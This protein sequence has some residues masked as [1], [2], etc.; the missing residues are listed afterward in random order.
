MQHFLGRK[1]GWNSRPWPAKRKEAVEAE[2]RGAYKRLQGVG[3]FEGVEID[4]LPIKSNATMILRLLEKGPKGNPDIIEM[5]KAYKRVMNALPP[6][7]KRAVPAGPAPP[8]GGGK[9]PAPPG[10]PA[11]YPR[12]MNAGG[13]VPG[14]GSYDSVPAMLTPGEYVINANAAG[15]HASLLRAINN[16]T[17]SGFQ[18]GGPVYMQN[19]GTAQ[20]QAVVT[21]HTGADIKQ[22][23]RDLKETTP[24]LANAFNSFMEAATVIKGVLGG[25]TFGTITHTHTHTFDGSVNIDISG[26]EIS[27]QITSRLQDVGKMM[28]NAQLI[29]VLTLLGMQENPF[30]IINQLG[31]KE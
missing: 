12:G 28:V 4:K 2:L 25:F 29:D 11:H 6:G 14:V 15:R 16:G 26:M 30:D 19:G 1:I 10:D 24:A 3:L 20:T 8:R 31:L 17:V 5:K 13:T 9:H 18:S 22:G 23:A 27:E 7:V 21:T